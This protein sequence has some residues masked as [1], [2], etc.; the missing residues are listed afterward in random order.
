MTTIH[1]IGRV[2]AKEF[3]LTLDDLKARSREKRYVIPRWCAMHLSVMLTDKKYIQIANVF[4]VD[5]RD[6][7]YAL[8]KPIDRDM[9][10]QIWCQT[11]Q[12]RLCALAITESL[13]PP[14]ARE[15]LARV[16]RSTA[17]EIAH[18]LGYLRD[19]VLSLLYYLRD[20][21]LVRAIGRD[22]TRNLVWVRAGW[23][24]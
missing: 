12:S 20:L 13:T 24:A 16:S 22:E 6:V 11:P 7:Y 9:L 5:R 17:K 1:Q 3:G 18:E 19:S 15:V 14:G 4:N 21:G 23:A 8:E 2:V 10:M